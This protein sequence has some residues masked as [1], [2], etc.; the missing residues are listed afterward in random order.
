MA[1]LRQQSAFIEELYSSGIV[2]EAEQQAMQ[3]GRHHAFRPAAALKGSI[4]TMRCQGTL[5]NM[6]FVGASRT[7][8]TVLTG[9]RGSPVA[10]CPLH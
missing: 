5:R 8:I 3:V 10:S 9:G 7:F 6:S 1:I 4:S 2:N